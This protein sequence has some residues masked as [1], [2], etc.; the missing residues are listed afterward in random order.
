MI[1]SGRSIMPGTLSAPLVVLG[2]YLHDSLKCDAVYI[3][4]SRPCIDHNGG[5]CMPRATF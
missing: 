4:S 5:Y 1:R 3:V 2:N